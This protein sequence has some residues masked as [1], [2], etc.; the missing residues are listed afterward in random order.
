MGRR[1]GRRGLLRGLRTGWTGTRG[2]AGIGGGGIAAPFGTGRGVAAGAGGQVGII[3]PAGTGP[4]MLLVISLKRFPIRSA[5]IPV[6]PLL[7]AAIVDAAPTRDRQFAATAFISGLPITEAVAIKVSVLIIIK[8][9]A[10]GSPADSSISVQYRSLT[11][12]FAM[13]MKTEF[14]VQASVGNPEAVNTLL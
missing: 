8:A 3:V 4:K 7:T 1:R 14:S 10:T 2:G 6:A 5:I 12:S 9:S 11:S 13:T